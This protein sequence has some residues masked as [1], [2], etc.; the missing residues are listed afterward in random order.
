MFAG[1]KSVYD[2]REELLTYSAFAGNEHTKVRHRH[3]NRHLNRV[4]ELGI[5]TDDTKTL[6]D[7]EKFLLC[8]SSFLKTAQG[9]LGRFYKS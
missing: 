5:G 7:I 8:H 6:F 1:R 9:I 4:M 3:L 2:L